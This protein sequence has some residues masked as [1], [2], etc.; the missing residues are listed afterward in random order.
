M[1]KIALLTLSV[2]TAFAATA[3]TTIVKEAER[4]MKSNKDASEVVSIIKPAF[5]DLETAT[6][7]QTWYIPG[8]ASFN[9]YDNM[10]GLKSFGKLPEGGEA[11]M[12]RLLISGYE[13]LVK[14]L[15]LDSVADAKGK[16]K[17]KYSNDIINTLTGH[18]PDYSGAGADLYNAKDYEGAYMSWD[19]F[20]S[21]PEIP[22]VKQALAKNKSLPADTI[23]GEIAF[24]QALAAWQAE[25]L[26]NSL[27]AFLKAKNF[28]YTKKTMF[29]YAISVA[30]QL[31]KKEVVLA[32]AEEAIPLYGAE[33]PMYM[34]QVV[35]YYLQGNDLDKA[36]NVINKAIEL[37]PNVAQY[38][39]IRGV[40]YENAN[41]N[42][43]AKVEYKKAIELDPKNAQAVYNYG[44]QL[45]EEAYA[46]GDQAP[47]RQDEYNQFF[48]EKIK[49]LF[50]EAV[51][52][53][54]EAYTLDP[55]NTDV[56][57]YLENVYYNLNDEKMLND[58]KKRMTY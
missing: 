12:G 21:L 42:S 44:R 58:V 29:D 51:Q 54:E 8:K 25:N 20:C 43:A 50:D 27:N 53:L 57:K 17:T 9:Q 4:A 16:I 13:Y 41:D 45:C 18:F 49:P 28:G 11:T 56:L 2:V 10:L 15:P 36:F 24:N 26:E 39:V 19:I 40:L 37:D 55:D 14:A 31:D 23:F 3:Q 52:V 35:N 33:D 30:T 47:T 34:G 38:Y 48:T 32:L 6:L 5:T 46:L 1:K 22:A 7:A